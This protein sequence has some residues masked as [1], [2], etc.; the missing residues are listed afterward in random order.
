M[1]QPTDLLSFEAVQKTTLVES[2]MEQIIAQIQRGQLVPGSKLPSERALMRALNVGRST[3]REAL[4]GLAAANLIETRSGQGSRVKDVRSLLVAPAC[5]VSATTLLE[6]H[7]RL[8]LLEM[9]KLVEEQVILWAVERATESEI[10]E[11]QD[12]LSLYIGLGDAGD[13]VGSFHNHFNFHL[14][15]AE[16][17]HNIFAVRVVDSLVATMP[18]SLMNK[19]TSLSPD[20]WKEERQIHR[21][22]CDAVRTRDAARGRAAIAHHMEAE[23]QQILKGGTQNADQRA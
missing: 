15:I 11:L 9:R 7:T 12:A 4:Q 19:Y 16:A 1:S 8:Q 21:D 14:A 13:W 23:R 6:R 2:V 3:V 5:G 17:S 22:I 20:V 10:A 18:P